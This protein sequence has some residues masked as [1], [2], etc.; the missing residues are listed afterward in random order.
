VV[1]LPD[2]TSVVGSAALIPGAVYYLGLG[3]LTPDAPSIGYCV[4]VGRAL[5][6]TTMHAYQEL[7]ILL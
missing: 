2:W 6:T 5:T 7:S 3:S 1:T 4:V